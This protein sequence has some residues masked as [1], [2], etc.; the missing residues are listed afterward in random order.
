MNVF[1]SFSIP[2]TSD[3][4]APTTDSLGG[5]IGKTEEIQGL[6]LNV[7][8]YIETSLSRADLKV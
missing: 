6:K 8:D 7:N 2:G 3:S 4:V 5:W 1:S